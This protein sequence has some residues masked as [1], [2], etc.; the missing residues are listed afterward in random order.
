[1]V[2]TD[3]FWLA[4]GVLFPGPAIRAHDASFTISRAWSY[5]TSCAVETFRAR[6]LDLRHSLVANQR[7]EGT[8]SAARS[9]HGC[10]LISQDCR[11]ASQLA[12]DFSRGCAS[13]HGSSP[14]AR[15]PAADPLDLPHEAEKPFAGVHL[16]C[17]PPLKVNS[18]IFRI[19]L[20]HRSSLLLA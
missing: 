2:G 3:V 19:L 18:S 17:N 14:R 15:T 13:N 1:M 4:H 6:F 8:F 12:R 20:L 7:A 11:H 9:I 5:D 10:F 16:P